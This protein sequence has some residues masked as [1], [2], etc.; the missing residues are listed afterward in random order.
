MKV[1]KVL[2]TMLM[3]ATATTSFAENAD[4]IKLVR[5]EQSLQKE[6]AA[7]ESLKNEL[8]TQKE[9]IQSQANVIDSLRIAID[10]NSKNIKTTADEIGVKIDE[11]NTTLGSKADSSDVNAK[12]IWCGAFVLIL[13][14]LGTVVYFLLHKKINKGNADVEALKEKSEK[15]NE[16]ILNQFSQE[17]AEMQKI[18]ASLS[19]LEKNSGQAGNG[20]TSLEPDH[21]LI[22]TLA[23]RITFMEMTLYRM[24]SSIKGHRPLSRS[25][26]QMKDN[27]IANGYELVDMLGKNY[28]DGMRVQANF[29]EDEELE[30]GARIITAIIKPQINYKG[31]M[32]QAAQITVSQN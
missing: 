6:I 27:L 16:E 7:R 23:D 9:V 5:L 31:K 22:K 19:A 2:L 10:Q 3:L 24:D 25:I 4:S 18:S 12:T 28:D 20:G 30:P 1:S 21:S 8:A 29:I 14:I 32:I 15:L 26:K 17:M 11:T 13:A